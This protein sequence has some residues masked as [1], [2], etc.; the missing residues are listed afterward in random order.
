VS[1]INESLHRSKTA[2]YGLFLLVFA[3]LQTVA[4]ADVYILGPGDTI[5][6]NVFQ[7]PDLSLQPKVNF[8]GTIDFPLIG[9]L[10]ITGL[11]L[12]QTE[13][14]LDK[15]LR[16]DYLVDPHIS[17]SITSYRHFFITGAV[18]SPGGYEYQPGMSVRRA[19]AI[20]GDF[21]D[22][23]SRSKIFIIKEGVVDEK[24]SKVR[25]DE[26]VGPGD[27]INVKESLF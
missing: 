22:R 15:K 18:K 1:P 5:S 2:L 23:A 25:P 12:A 3:S 4:Y 27:T 14:L 19:I 7:E 6:I 16:G 11:T 17:V 13:S 24:W 20:A 8:N 10:K 26:P 21:T 9:L